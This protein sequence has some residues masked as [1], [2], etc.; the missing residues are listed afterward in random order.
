[1]SI[2][3]KGGRHDRPSLHFRLPGPFRSAVCVRA[4]AATLLTAFGVLGLARSLAAFDDPRYLRRIE[5]VSPFLR[6][7]LAVLA[8]DS[9]VVQSVGCAAKANQSNISCEPRA[10]SKAFLASASCGRTQHLSV[11]LTVVARP[12]AR[13]DATRARCEALPLSRCL[14]RNRS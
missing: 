6:L 14:T 13:P 10:F 9:A 3:T 4:D 2:S 11:F 7:T 12:S 8:T 1:V 5:T